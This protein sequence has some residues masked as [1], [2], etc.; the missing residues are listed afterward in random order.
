MEFRLP[1]VGS[2][3]DTVGA[4]SYGLYLLHQPYVLY[5]MSRAQHLPTPAFLAVLAGLIV[6]LT[7]AAMAVERAVNRLT[8]RVLG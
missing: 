3:L 2:T 8:Q 4:Y 7:L 1:R 6:V 5:F